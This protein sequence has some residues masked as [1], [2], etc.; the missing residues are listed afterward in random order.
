MLESAAEVDVEDGVDD[1]IERG[2]DVAEPDNRV[3]D[4][5]VGGRHAVVAE[6]KDDVHEDRLISSLTSDVLDRN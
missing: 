4:A 5:V 2:V 1:G 3:D 6:R